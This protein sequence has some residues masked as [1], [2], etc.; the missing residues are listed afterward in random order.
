MRPNTQHASIFNNPT[1]KFPGPGTYDNLQHSQNKN[2][3]T[4]EARFRSP[5]GA[6]V[7]KDQ[8]FKNK[9]LKDQVMLPG[10]GN[11]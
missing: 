10:P 11:Y 8:R 7:P 3:F 9:E 6:V 5:T 2:G 1:K 4:F